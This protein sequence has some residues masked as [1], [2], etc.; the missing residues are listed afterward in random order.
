MG[1]LLAFY[2]I[3]TIICPALN[4][5]QLIHA[6]GPVMSSGMGNIAK[7]QSP[8]I[9]KGRQ[10]STPSGLWRTH[11]QDI[12]LDKLG[13]IMPCMGYSYRK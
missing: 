6:S 1:S 4:S 12:G 2:A 9:T 10:A 8:P 7:V 11:H 5:F 13:G 3:I